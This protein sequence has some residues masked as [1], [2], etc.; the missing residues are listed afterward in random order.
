LVR[1]RRRSIGISPS[2]IRIGNFVE[3]GYNL[4][5]IRFTVKGT[6]NMENLM[7]TASL[8]VRGTAGA[9]FIKENDPCDAKDDES[10][11]D[12]TAVRDLDDDAIDVR[13]PHCRVRSAGSDLVLFHLCVRSKDMND[14]ALPCPHCGKAIIKR[15]VI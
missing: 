15:D 9:L 5:N 14:W 3:A 2:P 4:A 7:V 11:K 10:A 6:T 8:S 12:E 1:P 13:C